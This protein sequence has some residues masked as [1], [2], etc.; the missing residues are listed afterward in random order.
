MGPTREREGA[1]NVDRG[2]G[3]GTVDYPWSLNFGVTTIPE[4]TSLPSSPPGVWSFGKLASVR[5]PGQESV[6]PLFTRKYL[7]RSPPPVPVSPSRDSREEV[8]IP[9]SGPVRNR[10]SRDV[11]RDDGLLTCGPV[12][13][14]G[15][16]SVPW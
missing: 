7:T 8:K 4:H 3:R 2:T 15:D 6:Y 1:V 13:D 14:D 11:L 9:S 12:P 10:S 5:S 16:P